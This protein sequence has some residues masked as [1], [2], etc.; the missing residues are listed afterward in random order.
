VDSATQGHPSNAHL[1]MLRV[2]DLSRDEL[3]TLS[4]LARVRLHADGRP[5]PMHVHEWAQ[6]HEQAFDARHDTSRVPVASTWSLSAA[7]SAPVGTFEPDSGAFVFEVNAHSRPT[8]P[9]I[10]VLSNPDF[11]TQLSE[12]GGGY[13]WALNSRLNQLTAWSNDPVM[14]PSSECFLIQDLM[15]M[16]VWSVTP[17]ICADDGIDYRVTH[18]QGHSHI[19]H[20]RDDLDITASWCVDANSAVKQVSLH[21]INL[22][23]KPRHLRL[24]GMVEWM[25]GSRRADRATVDTAMHRQRLPGRQLT[26][27][28]CT[29]RECAGG[30]GQGTAFLA[31]AREPDDEDDWTCDRREFFDARGQRVL[32]DVLGQHSGAGLDPCAAL[33]TRVSLAPGER[34]S[35]VFLL[36]Y[37]RDIDAARLLAGQA[38]DIAPRQRLDA[39]QALWATWLG[40][41][42]VKTP[43]PLFDALVNHWLLYQLISCRLWSKSGFYQ[44]GGAT[45]FRDQ[46]QDSMALAWAAPSML[47][48]QILRG[49]SRQFTEGDVQHWWHAPQGAGVRT[50]SSDDLLWLPLACVHYL[51]ATGD[52]HLLDEPVPF[53]TGLPI[54]AGAEDIYDTPALSAEHASVYEHA[55]RTIDRSLAVGL[56]GLPLMGSGD[57][58]DGM[59]RVGHLGHGESVW[60]GWFLCKIVADFAP[61]A[62]ARGEIPRAQRWEQAAQGWRAALNGTAWDGEW[63]TRAYFDNGQPLGSQTQPEARIDLIAQAWAVLSGAALP[64]LQQAALTAMDAMLVD[65]DAGLIKLLDPPLQQAQPSAGYIQAYPPGVRENGGQYTH[66]G[67]WALMAQAELARLTPGASPAGDTVYRYFTYLSPAHRA[68]HP[69]H[70]AVYGIEP[71]AVAGDVYTHEPYIGRGGW[72]WYTGAAGWLHRAAIESMFGLQIDAQTLSFSPCLPSHWYEAELTLRREERTMHF[73]LIRAKAAQALADTADRQALLLRPG[74]PIRWPDLGPHTCFVMALLKD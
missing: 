66:A 40:A 24:I 26:T 48:Q 7:S 27:L 28:L 57:W 65:Q 62:R 63:F 18:G 36:G 21:L 37:G 42:T 43:D 47:R 13:T 17:S 55:A 8:R 67:V 30:F 5:L 9:W 23:G 50:H 41:T 68:Q 46:L 60:L 74:Q 38:A 49:A 3:R 25:M 71:Y 1:H 73:I 4:S 20:R 10:N 72:S 19:H 22:S 44:A 59:N 12:T 16:R 2:E 52:A 51:R 39:V 29:Q 35:K 14:D 53:L 6:L 11:G 69:R 34:A 33:S 70:G 61:L 56:H 54:P 45:G 32:P 58:N 31:L 15:S 64:A